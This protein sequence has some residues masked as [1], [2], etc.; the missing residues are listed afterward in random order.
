MT[1]RTPSDATSNIM[2]SIHIVRSVYHPTVP[3]IPLDV[4]LADNTPTSLLI[5]WSQPS[6]SN[7][8]NL[9]Y[10]VEYTGVATENAVNDSFFTP[11]FLE[12]TTTSVTI[13]GLVPFSTYTIEVRASTSAGAGPTAFI[14]ATTAAAGEWRKAIAVMAHTHI[15]TQTHELYLCKTS[16]HAVTTCKCTYSDGI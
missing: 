6:F 13:I 15:D 14:N 3:S 5:F 8:A 7:G 2:S 9:T 11:N 12:I 10:R 4:I 16:T 1:P